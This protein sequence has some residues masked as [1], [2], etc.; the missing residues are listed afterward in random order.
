[1]SPEELL[2][3]VRSTDRAGHMSIEGTVGAVGHNY[4]ASIKV[5]MPFDPSQLPM[6][7]REAAE[8]SDQSMI[9]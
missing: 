6:L 3:T 1:M 9:P 5:V 7:V 8:M 4:A 2:L